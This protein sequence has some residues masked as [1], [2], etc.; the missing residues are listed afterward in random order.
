[1]VKSL[2]LA[3]GSPSSTASGA[4]RDQRRRRTMV[5]LIGCKPVLRPAGVSEHS[6]AHAH[7]A[8]TEKRIGWT[9]PLCAGL[10]GPARGPSRRFTASSLAASES[11]L[12]PRYL[13]TPLRQKK[14][15]FFY[16]AA[17]I[18]PYSLCCEPTSPNPRNPSNREPCNKGDG[19]VRVSRPRRKP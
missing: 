7:T 18:F 5:D 9:P 15:R 13:R 12:R 11:L 14:S 2:E 6:A 4:R 10:F 8:T 19:V 1:M 16:C 17:S 3:P